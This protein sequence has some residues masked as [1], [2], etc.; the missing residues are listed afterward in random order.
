M[1][2]EMISLCTVLLLFVFFLMGLEIGF[3]M[4]LAGFIGFAWIVNVPAALNLVAKDF[5]SVFSS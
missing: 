1:S 3:S 5:Y 2:L 4:A